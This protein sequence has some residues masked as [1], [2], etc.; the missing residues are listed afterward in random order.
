M[1]RPPGARRCAAPRRCRRR[2]QVRRATH[3]RSDQPL[4]RSAV[5]RRRGS[6][7]RLA[8]G[9][10]A[11]LMAAHDHDAWLDQV[12]D[13]AW[14]ALHPA[15]G[16]DYTGGDPATVDTPSDTAGDTADTEYFETD[17][18]GVVADEAG[19]FF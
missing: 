7:A 19:S 3:P 13:R 15:S 2:R 6:H 4:G 16:D 11:D 12:T 14:D 8:A 1:R 5:R 17:V 18:D 9:H 10:G